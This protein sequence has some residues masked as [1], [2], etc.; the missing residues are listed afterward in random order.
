MAGVTDA[1]YISTRALRHEVAHVPAPNGVDFEA[2]GL[3]YSDSDIQT[4][5]RPEIGNHILI[6]SEDPECDD[7]EWVNDP[8]DYNTEFSD[9]WNVLVMRMAQ[10]LEGLRVPSKTRGVVAL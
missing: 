5:C 3:V 4:D 2:D 1:M 6:G 7:K 9:Q 10:R 8:D